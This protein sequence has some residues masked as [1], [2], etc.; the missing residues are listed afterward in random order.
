M[1]P[2]PEPGNIDVSKIIAK[3]GVKLLRTRPGRREDE[4]NRWNRNG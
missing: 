1:E 4:G 3:V 2:W